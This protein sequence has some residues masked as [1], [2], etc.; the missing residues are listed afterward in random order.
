MEVE[1]QGSHS[2]SEKVPF[3]CLPIQV[4]GIQEQSQDKHLG[5]DNPGVLE[6][7]QEQGP[8]KGE[9][10]QHQ[11]EAHGKCDRE[12]PGREE[13]TGEHPHLETGK[14]IAT[15]ALRDLSVSEGELEETMQEVYE[16]SA[17]ESDVKCQ[18]GTRL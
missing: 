2:Q 14:S 18:I 9:G 6:E 4:P 17:K 16:E 1:H 8:H 10:R 3:L 13:A 15:Q 11:P 12:V 7:C 5:D